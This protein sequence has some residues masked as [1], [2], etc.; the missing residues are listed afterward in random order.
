MSRSVSKILAIIA[1]VV[2]IP[3]MIVGTAFV[4][5]YS[6]D[7]TINVSV[8]FDERAEG[9]VKDPQIEYKGKLDSSHKI[10]AGQGGKVEVSAQ[11]SSVAY[12]FQGWFA[13]NEQEYRA[14]VEANGA[15]AVE[16]QGGKGTLTLRV[17]MQDA[18][19]EYVAVYNVVRYS[20]AGWEYKLNPE[21]D[22][23]TTNVAPNGAK[24]TYKYGE[25]LPTANDL[26][27]P[28]EGDDFTFA[29]WVVKD[30]VANA[31]GTL[32]RYDHATFEGVGTEGIVLTNPWESVAA[33]QIN[34]FDEAGEAL[35][36]LNREIKV[37]EEFTL[38]NVR[39]NTQIQTV[40]GYNY[41]WTASQESASEKITK[42]SPTDTEAINVYLHKEAIEYAV[43]LEEKDAQYTSRET[44]G[45][46][47]TVENKTELD[48]LFNVANWTLNS[49]FWEF[50]GLVWNTKEYKDAATFVTDFVKAN[51]SEKAT[52]QFTSNVVKNYET[53]S[54]SE[55]RIEYRTLEPETTTPNGTV[56]YHTGS[57][58][59]D[60]HRPTTDDSITLTIG[61]LFGFTQTQNGE[62]YA[63]YNNQKRKVTL[64]KI[65]VTINGA[66]MGLIIE[67]FE[68]FKDLTIED[69]ITQ[70]L[71]HG[72]A[73]EIDEEWQV[74]SR[75]QT[76]EDAIP[77]LVIDKITADYDILNDV[78]A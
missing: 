55:G 21:Q 5:F 77:D 48:N 52:A 9:D 32:R 78:I 28:Y 23:V 2:I 26:A 49:K 60:A 54:V 22:A 58:D 56:K 14:F 37:G 17:D 65:N 33:A 29:G 27:T 4:A 59:S 30:G 41:F 76:R 62:W 6:A 34:F 11:I 25:A 74:F 40:D 39:E 68:Q 64:N 31:D 42:V 51:P 12:T 45:I 38:P 36:D 43:T 69:V 24:Q 3:L 73:E 57:G 72:A 46:T 1:M 47:F 20:I 7:K 71:E 35:T 44:A 67:N 61:E 63:V 50:S 16:W 8:M 18:A 70:I 19:D 75:I 15:D 53:F 66:E 13:G 10:T